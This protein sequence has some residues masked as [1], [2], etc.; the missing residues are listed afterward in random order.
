ML[1]QGFYVYL[2]DGPGVPELDRPGNHRIDN[3]M[4][5]LAAFLGIPYAMPPVDDLRFKVSC[6]KE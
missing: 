5:S 3:K 2:Y 1:F 4:K 6:S